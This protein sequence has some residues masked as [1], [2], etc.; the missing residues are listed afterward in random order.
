MSELDEQLANI[1]DGYHAGGYGE[2]YDEIKALIADQVKEAR[3]KETKLWY[4][5]WGNGKKQ[6]GDGSWEDYYEHRIA[7]L[8]GNNNE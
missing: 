8:K 2:E 1:M 6:I 5:E 7:G 3:I 4:N